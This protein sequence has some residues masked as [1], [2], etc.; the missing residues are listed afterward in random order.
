M[1]VQDLAL[2][3]VDLLEV[4]TGPLFKPFKVLLHGIP[5]LWYVKYNT[6]FCDN[7]TFPD[8]ALSPPVCVLNEGS[9]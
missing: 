5:S 9:Q 3:S 7:Y 6:H 8:G 1:L 2:G 4:P